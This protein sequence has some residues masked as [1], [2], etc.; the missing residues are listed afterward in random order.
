M[1]LAFVHI[2]K[3]GGA[4]IYR[5]W[6]NNFKDSNVQII[7]NGHNTIDKI[8]LNYDKSF[9]VTRNTFNKCISLY[10]F[11]ESKCKQRIRK[12]VNPDYYY[13]VLEIH[14]KGIIPYLQWAIDT[15]HVGVKSQLDYIKGV[16]IVLST[17]N[18]NNDFIKIQSFFDTDLPLE[19]NVH[20]GNYN[21]KD[22]I[23]KKYIKFIENN[24][25]EELDFFNYK[26]Y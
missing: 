4:S 1:N 20:V 2:P 23:D 11:Q 13:K 17:E 7:R 26:P 18:L 12:N 3:T 19:K 15:C 22:F 24:F 6:Y 9:T 5:W 10:V 16:D 21:K 14:S 25:E 8:G